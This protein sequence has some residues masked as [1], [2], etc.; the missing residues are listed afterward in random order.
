MR[1]N[2]QLRRKFEERERE[3][4]R[5][6]EEEVKREKTTTVDYFLFHQ[7]LFITVKYYA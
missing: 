6:R 4:E 3:R 1:D 5:E 2:K 7:K